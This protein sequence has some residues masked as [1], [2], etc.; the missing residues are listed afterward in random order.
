M[1]DEW[2]LV[3]LITPFWGD[4]L[5]CLQRKWKCQATSQKMNTSHWWQILSIRDQIDCNDHVAKNDS[6]IYILYLY[7]YRSQLWFNAADAAAVDDHDDAAAD[8]I[9]LHKLCMVQLCS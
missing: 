9:T 5:D 2:K 7:N 8:D 3:G 6:Y 1:S 4:G